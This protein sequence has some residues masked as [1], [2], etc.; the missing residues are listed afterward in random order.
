M[1]LESSKLSKSPCESAKR[2]LLGGAKLALRLRERTTADALCF[3]LI[4]A[5]VPVA[6]IVINGFSIEERFVKRFF[7]VLKY[8]VEL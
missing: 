8:Y 5:I 1:K 2:G 7:L 6:L 3:L 4:T